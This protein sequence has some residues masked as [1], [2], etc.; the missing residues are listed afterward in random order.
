MTVVSSEYSVTWF[1]R[2]GWDV[3]DSSTVRWI[4]DGAGVW[5]SATKVRWENQQGLSWQISSYFPLVLGFPGGSGV[6]N[7]AASAG[8]VSLTPGSGR[9]AGG[10][11][12]NPLQ[13]SCLGTPNPNGQRSLA[14][15]S[16]WCHKESDTTW[17]L[18]NRNN[19]FSFTFFLFESSLSISF[20]DPFLRKS[21]RTSGLDFLLHQLFLKY[22]LALTS[23]FTKPLSAPLN[24]YVECPT[25]TST[26]YT[27][28]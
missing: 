7:L 5:I 22:F 19:P 9:S 11:N 28:L 18:H 21:L 8:D 27:F 17:R 4:D 6:K 13:D 25:L 23:Y 2:W 24:L 10:G 12:G 15:Y 20:L 3:R 26:D 14:G 1:Y 16:P